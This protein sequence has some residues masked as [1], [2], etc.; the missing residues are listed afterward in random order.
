MLSFYGFEYL[1]SDLFFFYFLQIY[2]I[3][4]GRK[5]MRMGLGIAIKM[6]TKLHSAPY[7]LLEMSLEIREEMSKHVYC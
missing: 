1:P 7:H 2:Q 5:F 4:F 3:A 6:L